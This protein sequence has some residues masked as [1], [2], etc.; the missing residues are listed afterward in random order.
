MVN[1]VKSE[2]R[3]MGVTEFQWLSPLGYISVWSSEETVCRITFHE[4]DPE[5]IQKP[6]H[7]LAREVIR[8]LNAYFIGKLQT[9]NLPLLTEGTVFQ[10]K[11]WDAVCRIPYGRVASYS[12]L[13]REIGRPDATRAVA[14]AI[15]SNPLLI[16]IP[17]HRVVGSSGRL[18]GYAGGIERKRKLIELERQFVV[19]IKSTLF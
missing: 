11:V 5:N 6:Y 17:C 18:T 15:G 12:D 8:Q 4:G 9:F 13:G 16:V 1:E 3:P 19:S 14:G 2:Y 7:A 10:K